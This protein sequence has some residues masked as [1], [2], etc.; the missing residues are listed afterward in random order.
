MCGHEPTTARSPKRKRFLMKNEVIISTQVIKIVDEKWV[1]TACAP[2]SFLFLLGFTKGESKGYG[3]LTPSCFCIAPQA[4]RWSG[5]RLKLVEIVLSFPSYQYE[6]AW[7]GRCRQL[8]FCLHRS[9]PYT[10]ESYEGSSGGQG[11][12]NQAS[13]VV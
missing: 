8:E 10:P 6:V 12:S 9:D 3:L 5:S 1:F 2:L 4:A 11:W 13:G 7:S